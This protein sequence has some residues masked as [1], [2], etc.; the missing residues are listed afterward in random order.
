MRVVN[1]VPSH[2]PYVSVDWRRIVQVF[3]NLIENAVQHSPPGAIVRLVAREMWSE[4]RRWVECEVLD[5]GPGFRADDLAQLFTPFFT[6]RAG[7]T[8]LGLSIVQRIAVAHGGVVSGGNRE[9]G[10]ARMVV[11]LPVEADASHS[12]RS[13]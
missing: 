3:Q 1:E 9:T 4:D 8:G 2:L 6:T 5:S 11:R 12:G 10:G 7:G 13:Q